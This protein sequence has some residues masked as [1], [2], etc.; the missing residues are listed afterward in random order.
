MSA[1]LNSRLPYLSIVLLVL[2]CTLT[3]LTAG[4]RIFPLQGRW[5]ISVYQKTAV[6]HAGYDYAPAVLYDDNGYRMWWCGSSPAGNPYVDH[7]WTANSE[8]GL[9][10]NNIRIAMS[11]TPQA[12]VCDP[13]V[14]RL[15][16]LYRMYYTGT[17]DPTGIGNQIYLATSSDGTAWAKWPDDI[18][19]QPVISLPAGAAGY[20][21]GQPSVVYLN[22]RFWLYYTD[23]T[24]EGGGTF[25]ASSADGMHFRQENDGHRLL[26][27]NSVD[28]KY[29]YA[30]QAFVM[31]HGSSHDKLYFTSSVDGIHWDFMDPARYLALTPGKNKAFEGCMA[32]SATGTIGSWTYYYY[33]SHF[34]TPGLIQDP[35]SWDID[36]GRLS[37]S[38]LPPAG[39]V[40]QS[41]SPY[42]IA[43]DHLYDTRL[44]TPALYDYE[45]RAFAL[46]SSSNFGLAPFHRLYHPQLQD[47]FYTTDASREDPGY[48]LWLSGRGDS[49]IRLVGA[50]AR[51]H[52][53][54]SVV[55]AA[56][57]SFLHH[58]SH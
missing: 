33:A 17:N 58:R 44:Q 21:I 11:P 51:L 41:V 55:S 23:T 29:S 45:Y 48:V 31:L 35:L 30:L 22:G 53:F 15:N 47:H 16:G 37:F 36:V 43:G 32:G 56:W 14:V 20:G 42:T 46:E 10:W 50:P 25:L 12:M 18:N 52:A 9:N 57:R 49:G 13:S 27:T 2:C 6:S 38:A 3:F 28:V 34:G 54:V 26:A 8:D 19:P 1:M 4:N 7:I 39:T 5:G 40:F 24:R